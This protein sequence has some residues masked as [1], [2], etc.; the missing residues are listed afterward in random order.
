MSFAGWLDFGA[1]MYDPETARWTTPDP[2]AS[3]YPGISPYAYCAND[4]VNFVDPE[5]MRV[6][7]RGISE[8]AMIKNTIP[9]DMWGYIQIGDDGFVDEDLINSADLKTSRN[10]NALKDLVNSPTI[11]EVE[12]NN[13]FTY[14][15]SKGNI[16][17]AFMSYIPFD[18][19]FPEDKDIDFIN[20]SG[21]TTG[22]MGFYGKTLFPDREGYQNSPNANIMVIV[23]SALST[24][25]AAEA[26][27]HEGYGHALLYIRNGG[28]HEGASHMSAS[29]EF[30]PVDLN[31]VLRDMI[32]FS[33]RETVKNYNRH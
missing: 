24:L 9:V 28:N 4:P 1:R 22:E 27:S 18:P 3:Q 20:I 17:E 14:S 26:F 23:N 19:L 15:D 10:F 32:L 7:P 13:K 6:L 31:T 21:L 5:G 11:V 25:G 16:G 29:S 8:L 2:L 12:L 30:G 33:R